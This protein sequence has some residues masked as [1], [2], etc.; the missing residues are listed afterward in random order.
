MILTHYALG[1]AFSLISRLFIDRFSNEI[2]QRKAEYVSLSMVSCIS[3]VIKYLINIYQ[4]VPKFLFFAII[5]L[6][7]NISLTIDPRLFKFGVLI[8][9]IIMEG[10]VSQISYL[11]PS[12]N[13]M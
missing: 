11:G 13:F 4:I 5:F 12:L 7:V 1:D 8:L 9:D 3:L 2:Y 10:T 6:N